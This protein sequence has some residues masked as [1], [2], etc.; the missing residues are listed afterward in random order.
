MRTERPFTDV[1]RGCIKV[2]PR[3]IK[4]WLTDANALIKSGSELVHQHHGICVCGEPGD[5]PGLDLPTHS[6]RLICRATVLC[7]RKGRPEPLPDV[8]EW[9]SRSCAETHIQYK[10]TISQPVPHT[11]QIRTLPPEHSGHMYI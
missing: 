10:Y 6:T 9:S 8:Q 7:T 4:S 5:W 11:G 1:D 2:K 3:E